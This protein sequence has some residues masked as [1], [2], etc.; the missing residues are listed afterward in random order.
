MNNT[1]LRR[2][3]GRLSAVLTVASVLIVGAAG[4]ALADTSQ[5]TGQALTVQLLGQPVLSSSQVVA[6]SDGTSQTKTG[7]STPALS[8]LGNQTVLSAGLLFQDALAENDGASAACAGVI[9]PNGTIQLGPTGSCLA[10]G[11]PGEVVLDLGLAVLRADVITAECTASS[12]GS[13]TGSATL[14]NARITDP[15][16]AVTLLS[17]PVNP[18]PNTVLNVPGIAELTLNQQSSGAPGQLSVTALDLTLLSGVHVRSGNVTCGPNAQTAPIPMF[19]SQGLPVAGVTVLAAAAFL[20]FVRR[21][22]SST[23]T[24]A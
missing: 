17:L 21:R 3:T 24:N 14:A 8:I 16:G 19:S 1:D 9:G 11:T 20:W 12:S 22:R 5:T 2:V 18:A 6:S 10:S 4:P 7:T 15:T 23:P 13:T